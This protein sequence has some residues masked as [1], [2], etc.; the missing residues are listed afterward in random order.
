MKKKTLLPII[1]LSFPILVLSQ[2]LNIHKNDGSVYNVEI[3]AIDSISF[4]TQ[5]TELCP[6]TISYA[7]K[8][9]N[10]VQIGDQCWL[11]ENLDVGTMIPGN[12]DMFLNSK[13]EKYCYDDN[14]SN[15]EIYGGFYDWYEAMQYKTTE[16]TQGICP[17]GWHIPTQADFQTLTATNN[18][19]ALKEVGQ[20]IGNGIGTNTSG[21]SA[22]L[23][24]ARWSNK[25]FGSLGSRTLFWSSTGRLDDYASYMW[26]ADDS[27]SAWFEE[28]GYK[29]GAYCIRCLKD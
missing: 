6:E 4:S 25:E 29:L 1:L 13:I 3:N 5:S 18:G 7:G 28:D 15:C 10:T 2:T 21:F 24:G 8:V 23:S 14:P 22:L 9:Y 16:G 17:D 12:N 19:N 27:Y 26:L 11:K 20:G